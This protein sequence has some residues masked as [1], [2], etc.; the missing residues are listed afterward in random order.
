MNTPK[1]MTL[2]AHEF[3]YHPNPIENAIMPVKLKHP[4][5]TVCGDID[6]FGVG[7]VSSAIITPPKVLVCLSLLMVPLTERF[8]I[9]NPDNALT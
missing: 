1:L 3:K 9:R 7:L 6:G 2:I 8:H 4:Q 5:A